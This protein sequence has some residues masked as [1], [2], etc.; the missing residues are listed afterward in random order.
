MRRV[1]A[2]KIYARGLNFF[3]QTGQNQLGFF[4][5]PEQQMESELSVAL[6]PLIVNHNSWNW[7][8]INF[9]TETRIN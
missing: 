6:Y 8:E 7:P 2:G 9:M 1:M 5:R 4:G 3:I